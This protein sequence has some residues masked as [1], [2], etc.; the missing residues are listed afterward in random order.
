MKAGRGPAPTGRHNELLH[1]VAVLSLFTEDGQAAQERADGSGDQGDHPVEL[2][3]AFE[4]KGQPEEA[5]EHQDG[6]GEAGDGKEVGKF[7]AGVENAGDKAD[8]GDA[9]Q[10]TDEFFT[11]PGEHVELDAG[12]AGL[13]GDEAHAAEEN[14]HRKVI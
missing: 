8:G 12:G 9:Q 3:G 14:R 11:G 2:L 1:T 10:P 6:E 7:A 13:P 5:A 4:A